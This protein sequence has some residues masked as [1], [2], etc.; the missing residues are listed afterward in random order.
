[1]AL[2]VLC[3]VSTAVDPKIQVTP[4]VAS[5]IYEPGKSATCT[6]QVK[7]GDKPETV[8]ISYVVR[9]GGAGEAAKGEAELVGGKAQ[10]TASRATP[11]TLLAEIR[12][13][14]A[15][16]TKD[17]VAYGGAAFDPEKIVRSA[18]PPDDFDA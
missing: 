17:T 3:F 8:K 18:P 12:Y 15:G 1:V 16:A 5:G 10:V 2:L 9:P 7:D 4:D 11:G 6:V 13:R 14:A